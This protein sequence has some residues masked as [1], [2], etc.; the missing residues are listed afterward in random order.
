MTSMSVTE[1]SISVI[2]G[3]LA[4]AG[5]S[6]TDVLELEACGASARGSALSCLVTE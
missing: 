6:V 3:V 2:M 4:F 5:F 1:G